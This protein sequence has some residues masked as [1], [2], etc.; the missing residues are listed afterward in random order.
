MQYEANALKTNGKLHKIIVIGLKI[1]KES[2]RTLEMLQMDALLDRLQLI[3]KVEDLKGWKNQLKSM[4]HLSQAMLNY[5]GLS[6]AI[7]V[8]F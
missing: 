6:I 3:L 8:L 7:Y 5:K 2:T 1:A 4:A